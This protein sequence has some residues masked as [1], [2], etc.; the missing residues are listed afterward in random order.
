VPSPDAHEVLVKVRAC[1]VCRTDL[2]LIEGDLMAK[3]PGVV[4][5]HQAV[6][7]VAKSGSASRRF[8]PGDRVGIPCDE[9]LSDLAAGRVSGSAVVQM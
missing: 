7:T 5:G 6:G 3:A 1:G 2:H 8:M 4:A 9:A